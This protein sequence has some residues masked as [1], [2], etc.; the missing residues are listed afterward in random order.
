MENP[1]SYR[2]TSIALSCGRLGNKLLTLPIFCGESLP[3]FLRIRQECSH[4]VSQ[5]GEFLFVATEAADCETKT[6]CYGPHPFASEDL[7]QS[8]QV[9]HCIPAF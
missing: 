1:T 5:S 8:H 4:D 3:T 2:A 6:I 9:I 7:V